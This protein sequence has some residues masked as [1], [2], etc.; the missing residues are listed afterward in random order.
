MSRPRSSSAFVWVWKVLAVALG[1]AVSLSLATGCDTKPDAP[2]VRPHIVLITSDTLR[3]DH[4]SHRGYARETSPNLDAFAAEVWDFRRA[5][6]VVPKTGPSFTTMFTGLHPEEHKVRTNFDRIPD[7]CDLLAER[8]QRAGYQ[9]AAFVGNITL[10]ASKGYAGGFQ[11]Y[12]QLPWVPGF[13]DQETLKPLRT[14]LKEPWSGPTFVWIHLLDPHGPYL[15]APEFESMFISDSL[16]ASDLRVPQQS[17][18]Q[19][20]ARELLGVIP[21]HQIYGEEDRVSAYIA[22]YDAEIRFMDSLFAWL[23]DEL[24]ARGVYGSSAILFTSDHG[25]SLGEHDYYFEHGFLA[26]DATL[27]VPLLVKPPHGSGKDRSGGKRVDAPVSNVDLLP[28]VLALAG[29]E[30]DPSLHGRNLLE[31]LA[32]EKTF[33][34]ENADRYPEKVH[35]ARENRWKYLVR[36]SDGAEELYDL[37][38]DPAEVD[39]VASDHP[40]VVERL[41]RWVAMELATLRARGVERAAPGPSDDGETR[42]RLKAL[43]YVE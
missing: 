12:E 20:K 30:P 21:R 28:T 27:R 40:D 16:A 5:I 31:P 25:E 38:Q 1:T 15:P 6:T 22:R 18:E 26:Y 10:R 13:D 41:R 42:E 11:R 8:L 43:G 7:E 17:A 37:E 19:V 3:P 2:A 39:S 4:L 14:W 36:R 32:A 35:G 23:I 33:L 29:L 24:V 34:V 9:T